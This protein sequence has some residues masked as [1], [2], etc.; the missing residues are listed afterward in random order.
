MHKKWA[1]T[2]EI[3]LYGRFG[4]YG[5]IKCIRSGLLWWKWGFMVGLGFIVELNA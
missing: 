5:G 3:G 1:F 4:F 2:E